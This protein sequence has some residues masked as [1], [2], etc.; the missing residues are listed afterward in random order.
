MASRK[1]AKKAVGGGLRK[2]TVLD[3][4]TLKAL[5]DERG[6]DLE[7]CNITELDFSGDHF[8]LESLDGLRFIA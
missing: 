4:N 8:E 6:G 2:I 7:D 3:Q 5:A 1:A